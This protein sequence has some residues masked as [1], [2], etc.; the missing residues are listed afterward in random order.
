MRA[1][2]FTLLLLVPLPAMAQQ[3]DEQL[4]L[5]TNAVTSLSENAKVTLE[6]VGRFSDRAGGFFHYEIGGMIGFTVAKGVELAGGYRH[7]QDYDHGAAKPGEERTR[8]QVTVALGGGFATRLRVEQRFQESGREVGLRIRP[9]LRFSLPLGEKG[10]A[11]FANHEAF[12]NLNTTAWGQARGYERMRNA[13][14]VTVPLSKK[15]KGDVGYLNQ[16]RFGR[17]GARDQMDHAATF[18]LTLNL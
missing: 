9:S 12:I 18:A 17:G 1:L 3:T 16:Y 6:G 5:Q 4:W 14:G 10:V 11:L 15:L 7:V 2:L 8:Q 13:V